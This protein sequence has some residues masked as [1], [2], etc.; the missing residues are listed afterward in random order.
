MQYPDWAP[1][2]LVTEFERFQSSAKSFPEGSQAQRTRLIYERL[3]SHPNMARIWPALEK[4]AGASGTHSET[5]I[6]LGGS[7][8]RDFALSVICADQPLKRWEDCAPGD[9]RDSLLNIAAKLREAAKAMREFRDCCYFSALASHIGNALEA[10]SDARKVE[11]LTGHMPTLLA[12]NS[13]LEHDL[14]VPLSAVLDTVADECAQDAQEP[15]LVHAA[16][17]TQPE[18]IAFARRL[19]LD[20]KEQFGQPLYEQIA[21]VTD[22]IYDA[23]EI[24]GERVRGYCKTR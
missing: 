4:R 9:R 16:K 10:D 17:T 1:Q 23:P 18:P 22:A 7:W 6:S 5:T 2:A 11:A 13:H 3:L 12:V 14:S 21:G 20:M 8:E 15:P 19:F 24:T